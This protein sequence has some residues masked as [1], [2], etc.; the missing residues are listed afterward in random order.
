MEATACPELPGILL[1]QRELIEQREKQHQ[2]VQEH[3]FHLGG[4]ELFAEDE[5]RHLLPCPELVLEIFQL[6]C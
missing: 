3:P 1:Y 6:Y 5:G 2:Q 4:R